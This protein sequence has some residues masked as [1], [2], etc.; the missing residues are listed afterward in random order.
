MHHMEFTPQSNKHPVIH[1]VLITEHNVVYGNYFIDMVLL[2]LLTDPGL[3]CSMFV[4]LSHEN[5]LDNREEIVA[6]NQSKP[7]LD[8]SLGK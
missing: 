6:G 5:V 8:F 4:S 3:F 1:A 2:H 7:I